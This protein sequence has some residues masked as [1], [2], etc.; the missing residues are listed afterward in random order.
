MCRCLIW[1]VWFFLQTMLEHW[2]A[3]AFFIY[4]WLFDSGQIQFYLFYSPSLSWLRKHQHPREI[5]GHTPCFFSYRPKVGWHIS[6]N[7]LN[8]IAAITFT[9]DRIIVG[10]YARCRKLIINCTKSEQ[11]SLNRT[12]LAKTVRRFI[13][14]SILWRE[15]FFSEKHLVQKQLSTIS[16]LE[17]FHCITC[18]FYKNNEK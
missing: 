8:L 18:F 9:V 17:I 11:I 10:N 14:M 6:Q 4:Y 12:P 3:L 7:F 15:H 1:F 13:E 2:T 5:L 16:A